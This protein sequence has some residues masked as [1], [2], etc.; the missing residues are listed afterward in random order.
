MTPDPLLPSQ[1]TK[2]AIDD[3]ARLIRQALNRCESITLG[4]EAFEA[5]MIL[6]QLSRER[7]HMQDVQ[8]QQREYDRDN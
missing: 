6:D 3:A 2:A 4:R 8:Q 1:R 5:L 7:L